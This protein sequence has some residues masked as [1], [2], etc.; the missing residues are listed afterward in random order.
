MVLSEIN[1]FFMLIN[2]LL[3]LGGSEVIPFTDNSQQNHRIPGA[4]KADGETGRLILT[5][6]IIIVAHCT[7]S[8]RVH[9]IETS[10]KGRKEGQTDLW[11][12]GRKG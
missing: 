7:L 4:G 1:Y 2:L 11:I 3:G 10:G 8:M 12:E 5:R 6:G 9:K